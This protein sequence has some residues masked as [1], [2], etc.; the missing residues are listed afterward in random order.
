MQSD[1]KSSTIH[2]V[3]K[4]QGNKLSLIYI[5][6]IMEKICTSAYHQNGFVATHYLGKAMQIF[7]QSMSCHRA[8]EV[9]NVRTH[10]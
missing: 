8:S 2:K 7:L 4:F 9:I 5:Y 6:A 1:H 10:H 3:L